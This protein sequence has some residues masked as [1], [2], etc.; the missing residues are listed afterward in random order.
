V[1]QLVNGQF[2][3]WLTTLFFAAAVFNPATASV[4]VGES[5]NLQLKDVPRQTLGLPQVRAISSPGR[6]L[7]RQIKL[8]PPTDGFFT[9]KLEFVKSCGCVGVA[10]PKI[11]DDGSVSCTILIEAKQQQG[12]SIQSVTIISNNNSVTVSVPTEWVSPAARLLR[13]R[14]LFASRERFLTNP[15]AT[16]VFRIARGYNLVDAV[17]TVD[18]KVN[19][20]RLTNRVVA[21]DLS[22]PEETV[23]KQSIDLRI[24]FSDANG[25][26]G[27]F[28]ERIDLFRPRDYVTLPILPSLNRGLGDVHT[29]TFK[30][31]PRTGSS[32]GQADLPDKIES[33]LAMRDKLVIGADVAIAGT[34]RISTLSLSAAGTFPGDCK[35][36][37]LVFTKDNKRVEIPLIVKSEKE[38]Q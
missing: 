22:L 8:T 4:S 27:S 31:I 28:I 10:E 23:L 16:A 17:L 37:V 1:I 11:G 6:Q 34:G 3:A 9:E 5:F 30:L 12:L 19:S 33:S 2:A 20:I 38:N 21:F 36:A 29:A 26:E 24:R 13:N 25:T 35:A 32:P 18:G 7:V 15:K 14:P